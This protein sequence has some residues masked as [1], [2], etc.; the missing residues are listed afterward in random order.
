MTE[1]EFL[2]H[3]LLNHSCENCL[4]FRNDINPIHCWCLKKFESNPNG[5]CNYWQND[6]I[7]LKPFFNEFYNINSTIDGLKQLEEYLKL[8]GVKNE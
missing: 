6:N 5:I 1:I 4:Y 3:L 8:I 7:D 2:K